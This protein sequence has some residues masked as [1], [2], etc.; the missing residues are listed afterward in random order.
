M[1]GRLTHPAS[2]RVYHHLFHPP[3]I[4]GKDDLTGESLIQ[5]DD[6]REE[7]VRKRLII[8]HQ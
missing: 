8:Y 4:A 5:R 1:S 7:T 3:Q 2:G 6:D